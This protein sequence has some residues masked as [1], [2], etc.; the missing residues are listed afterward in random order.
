MRL[1][2]PTGTRSMF[3]FQAA[4][5]YLRKRKVMSSVVVADR[6]RRNTCRNKPEVLMS[7]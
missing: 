4:L 1:P 6:I 7:Q 3:T 2:R 5:K